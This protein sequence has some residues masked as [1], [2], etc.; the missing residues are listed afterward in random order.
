MTHSITQNY[1]Y[2]ILGKVLLI[3]NRNLADMDDSG[4]I[5]IGIS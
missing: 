4:I 2:F 5:F 3:F 1:N